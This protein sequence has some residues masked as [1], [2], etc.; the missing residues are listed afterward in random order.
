[1]FQIFSYGEISIK[2]V[3][4]MLKHLFYD[5]LIWCHI[6]EGAV[7]KTETAK[8]PTEGENSNLNLKDTIRE[9]IK[10][11]L[12]QEKILEKVPEEP[13]IFL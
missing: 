7:E 1:M 12:T 4:C 5:I 13:P 11:V 9:L 10:E 8:E 2:Q 3:V 6:P